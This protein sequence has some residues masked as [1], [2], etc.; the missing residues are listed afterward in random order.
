MST[1]VQQPDSISFSGNLQDFIATSDEAVVFTLSKDATVILEENYQP[2]ADG[3]VTIGI[4]AIVERLLSITIPLTSDAVTVQTLG[5]GNFTATIDSTDVAFTVIKGGVA[6][7]AGGAEA[8]LS[9]HFLTWQPQEKLITQIQPEWLG[10]FPV[11]GGNLMVA[12]YDNTISGAY[13]ASSYAALSAGELVSVNVSWGNINSWA[14]LANPVLAWDVWFEVGGSRVTPIQRYQLRNAT[15][16]EYGFVWVNTLGGIDSISCTGAQEEDQKLTHQNAVAAYDEETISEYDILKEREIRQSTGFL[17]EAESLWLKDFFYSRNKQMVRPDGSL[18]RISVVSSKVVSV[19]A[20]DEQDFEFTF[21]MS[22]DSQMLNLDR[23]WE[24]LPAPA[25]LDAFFLTNLL[26]ALT[27][28][29]YAANLILACQSPYAVGWQK[30]SLAQLFGGAL[31]TLIDNITIR[32]IGGKLVAVGTL[33]GMVPPSEVIFTD[34]ASPSVDNYDV[35]YAINYGDRAKFTLLI[36]DEDG[37]EVESTVMPKRVRTD[38]VINQVIWDFGG[39]P[40]T[41]RIII[42]Q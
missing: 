28:A 26:S 11:S 24:D 16:E 3:S 2:D 41:G 10:I 23:T 1:I 34:N 17:T 35:D 30:I 5:V 42:S 40:Q 14:D 25:G 8:W 33:G 19:S 4:K 36:T 18:R 22:S 27:E 15:D 21:R 29:S 38:G 6:E 13:P 12:V 20:E 32:L 9:E 7:L 31:P 39:E 37:N